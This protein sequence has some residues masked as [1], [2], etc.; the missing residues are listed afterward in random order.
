ML[1]ATARACF[2]LVKLHL[3]KDHIYFHFPNLCVISICILEGCVVEVCV[4]VCVCVHGCVAEVC[5]CVCMCSAGV[6][7]KC[8]CIV[9]VLLWLC[10]LACHCSWCFNEH[11]MVRTDPV[12]SQSYRTS[13]GDYCLERS[14]RIWCQK[15]SQKIMR[16][17]KGTTVLVLPS[18]L[19]SASWFLC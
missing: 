13:V 8:V 4:C 1:P 5:V 9:G 7:W 6:W 16:A 17:M 18:L 19:T 11:L 15:R 12:L 2:P 10:G 14:L 3:Q